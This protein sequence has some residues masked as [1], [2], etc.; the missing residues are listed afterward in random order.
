MPSQLR[1]RSP[2]EPFSKGE[3][4]KSRIE[5][6]GKGRHGT[7]KKTEKCRVF[8]LS[9]FL[10]NGKMTMIFFLTVVR[11]SS[12]LIFMNGKLHNN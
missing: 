6:Q 2:L 5:V 1:H 11:F 3:T 12:F 7:E 8:F 9:V 10:F 4:K